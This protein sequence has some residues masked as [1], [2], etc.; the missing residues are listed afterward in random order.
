MS[1]KVTVMNKFNTFASS[2]RGLIMRHVLTEN[3][4]LCYLPKTVLLYKQDLKCYL[5]GGFNLD[6]NFK[7]RFCKLIWF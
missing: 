1:R 3:T 2:F 6:D 4:I 7:F 5:C